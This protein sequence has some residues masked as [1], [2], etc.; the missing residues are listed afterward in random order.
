MPG[1]KAVVGP[2]ARGIGSARTPCGPSVMVSARMPGVDG[3]G[4]PVVGAGQQGD[5]VFEPELRQ[6][7]LDALLDIRVRVC[8]H[9]VFLR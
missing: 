1:G 5:L 7:A 4:V 8:A 3:G 9:G 2:C 6:Q